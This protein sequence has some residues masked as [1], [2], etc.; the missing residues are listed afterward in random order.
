MSM[1]CS[2]KIAAV[3]LAVWCFSLNGGAVS[4]SVLYTVQLAITD[5]AVPGNCTSGSYIDGDK[6]VQCSQ[7]YYQPDKWQESC[8]RCPEGSITEGPG[9]TD[10]AECNGLYLYLLVT[11]PTPTLSRPLQVM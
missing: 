8:T 11:S 2:D 3:A 9:A 4:F 7:G 5:R 1:V 6:C 10:K